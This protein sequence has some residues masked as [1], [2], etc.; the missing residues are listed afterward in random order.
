[1]TYGYGLFFA[2]CASVCWGIAPLLNKRALRETG[3]L[4]TNAFRALGVL[5]VSVPVFFWGSAETAKELLSFSVNTYLILLLVTIMNNVVGDVFYFVAIRDIGVSL[6]APITSSYPLA[7]AV[8][9]W[10]WFNEALTFSVLVG[11][12]SVVTGLA[13]LNVRAAKTRDAGSSRHLRGVVLA[14][15][16]A[17]CWATGLTLNKYL[18]LNGVG[19]TTMTFWRGI[20]FSLMAIACLPLAS[21]GERE[22]RSVSAAGALAAGGAGIAGLVAGGWLYV[23]SLSIIPMNVATPIASSSPLISA[24]FACAFMGESLR[25]IQWLGI[26]F[27]VAGAVAVGA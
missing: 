9:S 16:A 5:A 4:K 13:L 27:V 10:L 23:A 26:M 24:V 14:I 12:F 20:F 8:T 6:A 18:T 22:T 21:R 11:T 3:I 15:L 17:L 1:M 25:P 2:S 19:A 7:V